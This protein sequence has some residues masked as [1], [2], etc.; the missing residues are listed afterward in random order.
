MFCFIFRQYISAIDD[1]WVENCVAENT[2]QNIANGNVEINCNY[3]V[4]DQ[5]GEISSKKH[6]KS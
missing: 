4:V 5:T 1:I 2:K 6:L 3:N